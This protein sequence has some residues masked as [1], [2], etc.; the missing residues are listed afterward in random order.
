MKIIAHRGYWNK[1]ILD[2]SSCAI[3]KA[4][5]Y[6][7]G[8]ESDV[9]DHNGELVIS[10]YMANADSQH[11]DEVLQWLSKNNN[12]LC[13]AI[14]IKADGIGENLLQLLQKYNI[15]NYFTFDM[16]VPQMIEYRELG[17]KFFTR[18]SEVEHQPVMYEDAA[19]V[20]IDGFYNNDWINEKLLFAH[21]EA[22]KNVCIV[23]PELH[24][25]EYLSF[26]ERLIGY[27]I[28]FTKLML[29]TDYPDNAKSFFNQLVE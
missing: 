29:C 21:I 22:G 11:L 19:G 1:E 20:W 9:R 14:N 13:F 3:K 25:R 7:Y 26:W 17:L 5:L 23:S 24:G 10:H 4:L 6:G 2:N 8:F 18:Q 15:R 12:R 28:D 27:N 16:S